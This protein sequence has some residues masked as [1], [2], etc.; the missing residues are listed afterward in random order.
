MNVSRNDII[1]I[2]IIGVFW[3][4]RNERLEF[5]IRHLPKI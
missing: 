1:Y 2:L 5:Q 4:H 3:D